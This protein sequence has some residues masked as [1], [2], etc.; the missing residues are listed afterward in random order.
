MSA[1][2]SP[3]RC[4]CNLNAELILVPPPDSLLR[5]A[6][7]VI[8]KQ[9]KS[10]GRLYVGLFWG[11]SSMFIFGGAVMYLT[12]RYQNCERGLC[13]AGWSRDNGTCFKAGYVNATCG[14]AAIKCQALKTQMVK[15]KD[16]FTI[17]PHLR[18]DNS[19]VWNVDSKPCDESSDS[20]LLPSFAC[21]YRTTYILE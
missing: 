9:K 8:L 14:Q 2:S 17:T 10:I 13:M 16:L 4:V 5:E 12:I 21:A 11:L 7:R 6:N 18:R 20:L 19:T 1:E 15:A 3:N